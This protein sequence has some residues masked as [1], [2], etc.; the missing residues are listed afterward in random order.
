MWL[1]V[2]RVL[3]LLAS[4]DIAMTDTKGL[5]RVERANA[6]VC[7]KWKTKIEATLAAVPI[8]TRGVVT[9]AERSSGTLFGG[10]LGN[11]LNIL[12]HAALVALALEPVPW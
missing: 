6:A 7:I 2:S 9:I 5:W 8:E 1:L 10:G 11:E 12:T 4:Q 3:A